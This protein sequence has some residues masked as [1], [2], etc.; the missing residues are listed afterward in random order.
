MSV[1]SFW[2]LTRRSQSCQGGEIVNWYSLTWDNG[3]LA[4][5]LFHFTNLGFPEIRGI[6]FLAYPCEVAIIWPDGS[7]WTMMEAS[8][9]TTPN[10]CTFFQKTSWWFQPTHLK[11][12][13]VK[14][15][16]LPQKRGE[17]EKMFEL[18]PPRKDLTASKTAPVGF[19]KE[20][21]LFMAAPSSFRW[22]LRIHLSTDNHWDLDHSY[23][24][25]FQP[26]RHHDP[27]VKII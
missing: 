2:V 20:C 23:T 17:N 14:L 25:T 24:D 11:N 12:R 15:D 8:Q 7:W 9:P 18:P 16:H 13:L 21:F 5:L 27:K 22:S 19:S 26:T 3:F 6:P 4:K 1:V 10:S